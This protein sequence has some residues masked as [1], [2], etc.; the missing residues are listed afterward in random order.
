MTT[1]NTTVGGSASIV[2]PV[3]HERAIKEAIYAKLSSDTTLVALLGGTVNIFAVNPPTEAEYPCIVYSIT[4]S[5][6][7]APA[8]DNSGRILETVFR[9]EVFSNSS[10]TLESDNIADRVKTLLHG[11][12]VLNSSDIIC[13]ACFRQARERQTKDPNAQVWITTERFRLLSAPN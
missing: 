3:S 8:Q 13:Y 1:Q 11:Q 4:G 9:V 7:Y 5:S 2:P 6:E 10:N 12:N